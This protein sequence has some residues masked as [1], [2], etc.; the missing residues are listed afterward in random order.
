MGIDFTAACDHHLD[1]TELYALPSTLA[2][3]WAAPQEL[4]ASLQDHAR[5]D[6]K[7]WAWSR[8]RAFSSVEEELFETNH[9]T[10]AAPHGL[11]CTVFRR[12]I[13]ITHLA[14]WWSFLHERDVYLGLRRACRAIARLVRARHLVFLPDSTLPPSVASDLLFDGCSIETLL[15]H[16]AR[17][18]GEPRPL[19]RP[20]IDRPDSDFPP[21]TWFHERLGSE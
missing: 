13:E 3:N 19:P 2:R 16:L 5:D 1:W 18:V 4:E 11:A 8:D 20:F 10:L 7:V 21:E 12:T 6:A 17:H 15:A 9:L 14:R